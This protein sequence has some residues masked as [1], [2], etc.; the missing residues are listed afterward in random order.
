MPEMTGTASSIFH[1]CLWQ[2]GQPFQD[3]VPK[4]KEDASIG[5]WSAALGCEPKVH[6]FQ[7]TLFRKSGLSESSDLHLVVHYFSGDQ[8]NSPIQP[9]TRQRFVHVSENSRISELSDYP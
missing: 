6:F 9:L 4:G 1:K 8:H 3:V 5:L 2:V 7:L